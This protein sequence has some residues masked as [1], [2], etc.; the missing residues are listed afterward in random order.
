MSVE[1]LLCHEAANGLVGR[2]R[3]VEQI[4]RPQGRPTTTHAATSN[5]VTMATTPP[6]L[7]ASALWWRATGC[8]VVSVPAAAPDSVGTADPIC[9]PTAVPTCGAIGQNLAKR[10]C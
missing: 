2:D 3:M 4:P 7:F 8:L 9:S 1:G 5:Q 6:D 10:P